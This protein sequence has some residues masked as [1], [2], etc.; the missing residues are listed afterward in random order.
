MSAEPPP[1]VRTRTPRW[2]I[3]VLIV[4]L[5]GNLLVIGGALGALWHF[6]RI[7]PYKEAGMPPYFGVFLSKLPK[8]KRDRIKALLRAQRARIDPLRKAVRQAGDAAIAEIGADPL[9]LEKFKTLYRTYSEAR[10]SL[11]QTRAE[12]VP[13]IL[14]LLSLEERKELLRIRKHRRRWRYHP[15]PEDR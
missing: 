13:E 9:D 3:I 1:T 15:P 11:R 10:H 7:R 14:R 4:S 2:M 8:E 5:A 6:K 12:V